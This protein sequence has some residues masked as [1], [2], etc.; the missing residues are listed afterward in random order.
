MVEYSDR[1]I[2]LEQEMRDRGV[3]RR[4]A[5]ASRLRQR[6]RQS[7]TAAGHSVV[8]AS[9]SK[10]IP[11]LTEW[12]EV[13]GAE[14][15]TR[16]SAAYDAVLAVPAAQ[17]CLLALRTCLDAACRGDTWHAACHAVA[18]A[19]DA[20]REARWVAKEHPGGWAAL[21]RNA[22]ALPERAPSRLRRS[23]RRF[24]QDKGFQRWSQ[25][26]RLSA[27][28]LLCQVVL[29]HSGLIAL[30][31]VSMG[32]RR[33][34]HVL[35]LLPEVD[36]W[37]AEADRRDT[38]LEP[39]YMP[40]VDVPGDWAKDQRGGYSTGLVAS[41]HLVKNRSRTTQELVAGADM[42]DVYAAVNALQRTAWEVNPTVLEVARTLWE[43][44]ERWEGIGG[45]EDMALPPRPPEGQ[46]VTADW[47]RTRFLVK[48]ENLRRAGQ[49]G[50]AA[51]ILWLAGR[52]QPEG[53]FH[54]P[55]QLDFRGRVYP[56][57]QF[58]Q[59]QGPDLAR[60]LLRFAEGKYIT[61][62]VQWF[63]LHGANCFGLDKLSLGERYKR[64]ITYVDPIKAVAQD[65]IDCRWWQ[66]ADEPW[67]FLAWCLEAGEL[68]ATGRVLTRTPCYIDGSNNGLQILSLLLRDPVG[69]SATNCTPGDRRDVY[70]DVADAVTTALREVD[71]DSARGWLA[72]FEGGRM[73]RA[74]AKRPV[75]TL[76]Y[77]C[78]R[79]SVRQYVA[80]WYEEEV[81]Q[82]RP[83]AWPTAG[84]AFKQITVL[85]ERL[86]AAIEATLGR[87]L[88]TMAWMRQCADL[89]VKSGAQPLWVAPTGFPV[90]SSYP[91]WRSQV[92]RTKLGEK[93]RWVR[94]RRDAGRPNKRRHRNGLPPNFVH[95]L[96]A[97][98]LAQVVA[99][100]SSTGRPV[101]TIHDSFGALAPDVAELGRIVRE[102]YAAMFQPDLLADLRNQLARVAGGGVCFPVPPMRGDLD[103]A[104]IL[105]SIYAFS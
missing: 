76:P 90:R 59:P 97:S 5:A 54:Y 41:Q 52:M 18:S 20:E 29:Q 84:E 46:P 48:R 56:V 40:M 31:T 70:Q 95:S 34:R 6:G 85:A 43:S 69:G 27:G 58:L 61:G 50:E 26:E 86:W 64:I 92:I 39:L 105:Q 57:S 78:T 87:A 82:G 91:H 71:D 45:A 16:R 19:L 62:E 17:A 55:Q 51:R 60:G 7:L 15:P 72:W 1:E 94:H 13:Q 21:R 10:T 42:P 65:P 96:D 33:Q 23:T 102:V 99:R 88:E 80:E 79:W 36:A 24:A 104:G 22:K 68:L 4:Q 28:G 73:P 12:L 100:F 83:A 2:E 74:A 53:R 32:R 89:V 44:G 63:W 103:P 66:E 98:A 77:G 3:E 37:I 67:Q 35:R 49:R 9:L 14:N 47:M 11:V 25:R 81:R 38:M 8:R 75:M 30:E 93:V 101:S